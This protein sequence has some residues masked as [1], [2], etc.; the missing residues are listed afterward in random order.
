MKRMLLTFFVVLVAS[1]SAQQP[2]TNRANGIVFVRHIRVTG[3][4]LLASV[5]FETI[6]NALKENG[7]G[8]RTELK[9]DPETLA[10]LVSRADRVIQ[11]VYENGG[12]AVLVEHDIEVVP[13]INRYVEIHFTVTPRTPDTK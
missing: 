11:Q 7:V 10:E 9:T 13:P 6:Q 8:L 5:S 2:S 4:R 3:N 1:L 12:R